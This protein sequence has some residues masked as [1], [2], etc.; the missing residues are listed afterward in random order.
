MAIK[1]RADIDGLRAIAVLSVIFFHSGIPGFSGGFVGVD[2]FFVISGYL[3]TSIIFKDIQSGQFSV[4][5]FYERRIRRIFPALFPVI[6]FT[7]IISTVLF[8]P[9]SFASVG[10]SIVATTFFSSNIL[11]WRDC[12]YFDASS[13][14]KPLLHTWSLA[15]EEQ[16]YIFYPLLLI[17]INRF[18]KNRYIPWITGITLISLITS[19]C[20]VYIN[21]MATFYLVPTRAWELLFGS[22]LSLEIIPELK[23]NIHRN[24]L[25]I[26]GLTLIAF[27]VGFYTE[28]TPF[29]GIAA[30]LPVL[31]SSLI[32]YSGIGQGK[33]IVKKIL[34]LKPVVFI[35]LTS[36]SL[37]LWHW[38]LIAFAKYLVFRPLTPLE[39]AGIIITT[40]LISVLSLKFIEHPFRGTEPLIPDRKKLFVFSVVV[41]LIFSLVGSVILLTKGL[42]G[43]YPEVSV[44]FSNRNDPD[45]TETLQNVVT[46][47]ENLPVTQIGSVNI[48]PS[49]ILWGDSHTGVLVP[50][51]IQMS[52]KY[53]LSGFV[54]CPGDHPAL[55]G[56]DVGVDKTHLHTDK[57]VSFIKEH[58]IVKTVILS[59]MW[60]RYVHG[61][62]Y[63]GIVIKNLKDVTGKDSNQS[64]LTILKT[65]LTRTVNKMISLGCE[66]VIVSDVPEIGHEAPRLYWIKKITSQNI[67]DDL[68]TITDYRNW[69]KDVDNFLDDLSKRQNVTI[70]RPE[71]MFFDR[72]GRVKITENKRILYSDADHLSPDGSFYI[73][74]VFEEIFK[75]IASDK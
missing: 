56:V 41:M 74:P 6:T 58:P 19:I 53:G 75:K 70:I 15:V 44:P 32:I 54:S 25:S 27:S 46:T 52:K 47:I 69:N 20:G 66:V 67:D 34:S 7:V 60:S 13:I 72:N 50:M 36:Y 18:S 11:F 59:G 39:I 48:T 45:D 31:G 62:R 55:L 10:K 38:P 40:I 73:A 33:S 43:R 57:I 22:L 17:G 64:N 49:F 51:A 35:G 2:V 26:T 61:H 16:F 65:S 42:P 4:A 28:T 24:I 8:D 1:Y 37:Y 71:S 30:M 14:T 23:S 21:Q 63:K 68:P 29:P 9:V 3:I 12:G 5:Q